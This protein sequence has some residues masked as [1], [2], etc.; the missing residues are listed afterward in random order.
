MDTAL[1]N[2]LAVFDRHG[3]ILR[4]S[5]VLRVG[6]HPRTRYTLRDQVLLDFSPF[7]NPTGLI[8][9]RRIWPRYAGR[10]GKSR[11]PAVARG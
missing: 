10:R 2:A 7:Q 6:I 11:R 9:V 1:A 8:L 4:T 5:D 3:G